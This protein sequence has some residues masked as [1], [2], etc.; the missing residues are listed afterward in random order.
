MPPSRTKQF[1]VTIEYYYT[2]C[3]QPVLLGQMSRTFN[4]DN[5]LET[6]TINYRN[7]ITCIT[8]ARLEEDMISIEQR[9]YITSGGET[10]HKIFSRT[11]EKS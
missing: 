6:A 11:L 7:T 1:V 5:T 9:V 3:A 2:N 8:S 4:F 10:Q